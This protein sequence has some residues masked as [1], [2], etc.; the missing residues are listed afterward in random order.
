M[1][2]RL[3]KTIVFETRTLCAFMRFLVLGCLDRDAD[4]NGGPPLRKQGM[5]RIYRK[6][7]EDKETEGA[8]FATTIA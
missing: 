2:D 4:N 1:T 8:V 3:Q 5:S 7:P 6:Q